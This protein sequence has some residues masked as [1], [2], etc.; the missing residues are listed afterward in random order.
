MGCWVFT[1][2]QAPHCELKLM[3]RMPGRNEMA[4]SSWRVRFRVVL[5]RSWLSNQLNELI[6]LL[7]VRVKKI[8]RKKKI[9]LSKERRNSFLFSFSFF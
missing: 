8:V 9:K 7:K 3:S 6:K 4:Q 5:V 2:L 1:A